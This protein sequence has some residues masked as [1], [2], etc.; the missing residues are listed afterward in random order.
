MRGIYITLGWNFGR[1]LRHVRVGSVYTMVSLAIVW[2]GTVIWAGHRG[3][4]S[5]AMA[6]GQL[7]AASVVLILHH[8]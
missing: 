8:T 3:D 1:M 4:W 6:F 7:L 2:F 5:T